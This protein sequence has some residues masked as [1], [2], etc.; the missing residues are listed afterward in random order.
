MEIALDD[1]AAEIGVDLYDVLVAFENA[2][3]KQSLSARLRA[4]AMNKAKD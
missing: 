3:Q 1:V 2:L 4:A